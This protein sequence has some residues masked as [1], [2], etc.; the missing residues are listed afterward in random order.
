M[1][2]R[3][4]IEMLSSTLL[5]Q[6]FE[7]NLTKGRLL[8]PLSRLARAAKSSRRRRRQLGK[9]SNRELRTRMISSAVK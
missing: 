9:E 7:N 6:L 4:P 8:L 1:K 5:K 2:K 3:M